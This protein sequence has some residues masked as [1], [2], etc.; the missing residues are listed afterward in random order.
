MSRALK[1]PKTSHG[2]DLLPFKQTASRLLPPAHALNIL[3][4]RAPDRMSAAELAIR[5]NDWLTLIEET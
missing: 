3:L 5:L 2:I 1:C 4:R